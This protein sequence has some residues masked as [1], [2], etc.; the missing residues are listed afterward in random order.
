MEA[1]K[2]ARKTK[3]TDISLSIKPFSA[4]ESVL[5]TGIPFFDHMLSHIAK[6]GRMHM[7]LQVKGDIE[8]DYHHTVEDVG[9]VLGE[10]F[11]QGLADMTG[12]AR[13]GHFTLPME[14]VLCTVA[15][16]IRKSPHFEFRVPDC[17]QGVIGSYDCELI[18]E[19]FRALAIAARINLH[20]N[21]AYGENKHHIAEAIYKCFGKAF[22]MASA[23]EEHG[24]LYSTK[25]VL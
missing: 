13:Y 2:I 10:A 25:G 5:N 6:H 1:V 20:I 15:I 7:D 19:F 22:A 8:V 14:E 23:K 12:V 11:D 3:E 16:D 4:K 24:I 18:K 9:I 21:V 17:F